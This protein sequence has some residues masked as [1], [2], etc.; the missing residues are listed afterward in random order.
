[1]Y[2]K[3]GFPALRLDLDLLSRITPTP[4]LVAYQ[5]YRHPWTVVLVSL[6][7]LATLAILVLLPAQPTNPTT[8]PSSA[9]LSRKKQ[10]SLQCLPIEYRGLTSVETGAAEDSP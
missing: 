10:L 2:A 9:L 4:I 5:Q 1:M 8:W 3:R 7:T 6:R